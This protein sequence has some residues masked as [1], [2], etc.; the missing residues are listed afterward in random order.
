MKQN[1]E[2]AISYRYLGEMYERKAREGGDHAGFAPAE[3]ALRKS[4]ALSPGS[5]RARAS[6]AAVL[7]A[8]HKFAEALE[9]AEPRARERPEDIDVLS[10]LGDARLEL[11][12]YAAAEATYGALAELAA[13]PEVMARRANL[14]ELTGRTDEVRGL[15]RRA[16]A[17]AERGGGAKAGAWYRWRLGELEFDSGRLDEAAACFEAVP[18]GVDARHDATAGLAR[19][20]AAQGRT[21]DA[22]ELYRKAIAIGPDAPML[23]A[24]GDLLV[25]AG[26]PEEAEPLFERVVSQTKDRPESRRVLAMFVLEH[27][28]D[29][30]LALELARRDF[31]E[32]QDIPGRDVLA[33][34][35]YKNGRAE[36]AAGVIAEALRLG[37][38]DP[39]LHFHAGLIE[40][41]LGHPERARE[42]LAKALELNP[43]FSAA[44]AE[45]ARRALRELGDMP[46]R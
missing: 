9:I 8:R 18:E 14:L 25:R 2:D 13:V 42:L 33:W 43:S 23:A 35:L 4:L 12:R 37:S 32:R 10:T 20:R 24:L 31:A 16:M 7:C 22:I 34:A 5:P 38:R 40:F 45:E 26:K 1:P 44:G 15:L 17:E 28:R 27:D 3:A 46:A 6:L 21:D 41:R 30:A 36:E 29:L 39:R 11:G 19:V